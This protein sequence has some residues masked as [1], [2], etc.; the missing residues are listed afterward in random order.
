MRDEKKIRYQEKRITEL[1]IQLDRVTKE[2]IF[3]SNK[4]AHY[5]EVETLKEKKTD[6]KY[7]LIDWQ[8]EHYKTALEEV[9][10][11]RDEYTKAVHDIN[12]LKVEYQSKMDE[13]LKRIRRQD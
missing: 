11:L 8:I 6:K 1:E 5:D 10:Q 3:L 13:Q 7:E 2:N 12:K 9:K 4:L